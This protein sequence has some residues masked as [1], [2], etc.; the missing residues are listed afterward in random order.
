MGTVCY[1]SDEDKA[2]GCTFG[3]IPDYGAGASELTLSSLVGALNTAIPGLAV[4]GNAVTSTTAAI[5]N[6]NLNTAIN[7][8]VLAGTAP[9]GAIPASNN[10]G[11]FRRK[12]FYNKPQ[13]ILNGAAAGTA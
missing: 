5:T 13:A 7:A 10:S 8:L 11:Y 3:W 2:S 12:I 4:A 1:S 6:A 9:G